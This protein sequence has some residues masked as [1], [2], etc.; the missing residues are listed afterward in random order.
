MRILQARRESFR[1]CWLIEIAVQQPL[2]DRH[3]RRVSV[4]SATRN[5]ESA[6]TETA[7][8]KSAPAAKRAKLSVLLVTRDDQ[9]WPQIGSHVSGQLVLKQLD[10]IDELLSATPS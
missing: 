8:R 2:A 4:Q 7:G 1:R 10:S 9:L 6:A 3:S 5:S